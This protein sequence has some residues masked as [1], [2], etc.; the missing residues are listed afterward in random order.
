MLF[1]S[2]LFF[3]TANAQAPKEGQ[4]YIA[5]HGGYNLIVSGTRGLDLLS[6]GSGVPMY[7]VDRMGES[8]ETVPYSF[9]KGA[10]VG[11]NL[12]YMF[13]PNIGV[14]LG[15]DYLLGAKNKFRSVIDGQSSE[16]AMHSKMIQLRPTMVVSGGGTKI[17]PY[18]KVGVVLGIGGKII[19]EYAAISSGNTEEVEL[20]R[21]KGFAFGFTGAG[22]VDF[23]INDKISIFSEIGFTGL[24]FSPEKG[25]VT[26]VVVN[27]E[28]RLP[29]LSVQQTQFVY[30]NNANPSAGTA[31]EPQQAPRSSYNF[32]SMGIT[33][34][35]KFWL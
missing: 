18:A 26:K 32:N 8:I 21:S 9:G 1:T 5:A 23:I 28:D 27:G 15:A 24:S 20:E 16:L 29:L 22:G 2:S 33:M 11:I 14:E 10:N 19:S 4:F 31:N 35:V 30:L 25:E 7:T 6:V 13:T 3:L 17:N 12:G 34:G